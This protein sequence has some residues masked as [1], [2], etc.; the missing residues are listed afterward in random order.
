MYLG[1]IPG[2]EKL[3]RGRRRV[4]STALLLVMYL[5]VAPGLEKLLRADGDG[6]IAPHLFSSC[7]GRYPRTRKTAER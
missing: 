6:W 1:V 5:V 4:H 3:L 2:L 7:L